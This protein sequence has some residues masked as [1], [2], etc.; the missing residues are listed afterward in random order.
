MLLK[1]GL[2]ELAVQASVICWKNSIN[3]EI[4]LDIRNQHLLHIAL[5]C[6][7]ISPTRTI[8]LEKY[9]SLT[10]TE[11]YSTQDLKQPVLL[12]GPAPG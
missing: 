4:Q 2:G 1:T 7:S 9:M 3:T 5:G 12:R 10:Q 11:S 8:H 6:D